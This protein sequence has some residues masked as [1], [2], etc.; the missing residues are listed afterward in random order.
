YVPDPSLNGLTLQEAARRRKGDGALEAQLETAR[1]MLRAGGASMVY[2]LMSDED[3]ARIARHPQVAF[4]SDSSVLEPGVGVPHPR[5]DGN[6][7]RILGRYVRELRLISV[8]D[9]VRKLTALPAAHFRLAGRGR[10][11]P[12]FSADLVLFDPAAVAERATFP[13]PHA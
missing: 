6:T 8:D 5:G 7:A 12:G 2:H 11:E 13:Q 1:E 3:V 9:A 4:A 10:I